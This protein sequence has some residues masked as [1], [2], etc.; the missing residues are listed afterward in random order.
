MTGK[1]QKQHIYAYLRTVM[2][3]PTI[4][5]E[6]KKWEMAQNFFILIFFPLVSELMTTRKLFQKKKKFTTNRVPPSGNFPPPYSP[7]FGTASS[8]HILP[9]PL[10][11]SLKK[12]PLSTPTPSPCPPPFMSKVLISNYLP[13]LDFGQ[14]FTF[15]VFYFFFLGRAAT[16]F[17]K[18]RFRVFCALFV[19][20]LGE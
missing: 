2:D 15:S 19:L 3:D 16:P 7:H 9:F 18:F 10:L 11:F 8:R 17:S 20:G 5:R 14:F 12:L 6:K 1:A 4:L 13:G